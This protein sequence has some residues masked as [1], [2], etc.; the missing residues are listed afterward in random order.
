MELKTRKRRTTKPKNAEI[1]AM[2]EIIRILEPLSQNA[3][4]RILGWVA[5]HVMDTIT[6]NCEH[7]KLIES[8]D[9]QQWA[10]E[11][12]IRLATPEQA[13]ELLRRERASD[14]EMAF[15]V[16]TAKLQ[17]ATRQFA[18]EALTAMKNNAL[19]INELVTTE[20]QGAD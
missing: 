16:T 6:F 2:T 13:A 19:A 11:E 9:L 15:N 7:E 18:G 4:N 10:K 3:K 8:F 1:T 20:Y 5:D 17:E 12:G 14:V